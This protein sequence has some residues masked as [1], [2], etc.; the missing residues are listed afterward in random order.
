[1]GIKANNKNEPDI[2]GYEMKKLSNKITF[3]DW[4]ASEYLYS[5]NNSV[6]NRLNQNY[7]QINITKNQFIKKIIDIHGLVH[8]FL[9]MGNAMITDRNLLLMIP[10]I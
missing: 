1:M 10:M 2:L 6:L 5:K 7:N 4:S 8:V 3:G 9:N